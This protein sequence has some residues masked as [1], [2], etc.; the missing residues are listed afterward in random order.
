MKERGFELVLDEF[1]TNPLLIAFNNNEHEYEFQRHYEKLLKSQLEMDDPF[2][3]FDKKETISSFIQGIK[4][5]SDLFFEEN[6]E[7]DEG[8]YDDDEGDYDNYGSSYEKYGGYNGWSDDVIDDA[9]EGDP[10][11]TWNVD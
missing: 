4:N 10:E 9:F 11:N 8:D 3:E 5:N 6:I 2:A 7:D 1:E